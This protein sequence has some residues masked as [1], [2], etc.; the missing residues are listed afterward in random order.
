MVM[1]MIKEF[2]EFVLRGNVVDLAVGIVIGAAFNGL[3]TAFVKDLITPLVGIVGKFNFPLLRFTVNKSVFAAGDFLNSIVT[4]FILA[5]VV[6]FFVVKPINGLV[7]RS[8]RQSPSVLPP[9][10]L[11]GFCL[12][13]I[14]LEAVKCAF[15]TADLIE[16]ESK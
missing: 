8:K 16:Q 1:K 11:C 4:F 12:S 15:C 14:N 5:F 7:V 6:F 9:T 2:K 10:K 13:S 3:V